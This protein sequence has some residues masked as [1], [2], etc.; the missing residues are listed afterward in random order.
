MQVASHHWRG[1]CSDHSGRGVERSWAW[2]WLAMGDYERALEEASASG[3]SIAHR[4]TAAL[5]LAYL[6]RLDEAAAVADAEIARAERF[7]APTPRVVA[8]HARA[9]AERDSE[10]RIAFCR[11][12][13][14]VPCG[15]TAVLE[16]VRVQ[17]ELGATLSRAG[18]R[19]EARDELRPALVAAEQAG[20]VPLAERAQREL[21]ASG[22]RVSAEAE[23]LTPR[24]R[25][26]CE[27]AAAGKGNREIANALF[28]SVKTVETHLAAGYRKLGVKSRAELA[29]ALAE[30]GG[31]PAV[32]GVFTR[33]A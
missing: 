5:A 29:A 23:A 32:V 11:R 1:S 30:S 16:R 20:A 12:A 3:A 33:R 17:L 26:I 28:L 10:A 22:V 24:Q 2:L 19:V 14:A 6:G 8:L 4:C 25:Q 15:E 7:D 9:L 27:L 13:L 31:V 18:A 21:V